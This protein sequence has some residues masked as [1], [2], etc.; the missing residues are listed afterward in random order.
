MCFNQPQQAPAPPPPPM[1]PTPPLAPPTPDLPPPP[2]PVQDD[3]INPK[4]RATQ[5]KKAKNPQAQGTGALR[6]PLGTNINTGGASTGQG[7]GL[8][9]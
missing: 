4:V 7:G 2:K 3:E 6:I 9:K 5:S 8:N 1:P